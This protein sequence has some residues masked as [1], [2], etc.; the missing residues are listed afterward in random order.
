M[1]IK[2]IASGTLKVGGYWVRFQNGK[3]EQSNDQVAWVP[4]TEDL[5]LKIEE[6]M[7]NKGK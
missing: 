6:F 4:V 7:R 5:K 3:W 2:A 1:D